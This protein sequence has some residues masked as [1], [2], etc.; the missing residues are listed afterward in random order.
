MAKNDYFY[1]VYKILDY[2]YTQLKNG[3][4]ID[5]EYLSIDSPLFMYINEKYLFYIFDNL[6][7]DGYI[8]GVIV[9]KH[10]HEYGI[11][12]TPNASITPKGIEYLEENN[13][14]N[15]VKNT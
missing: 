6:I 1:L 15:K 11:K 8:R 13:I 12:I 7:K 4:E 10:F 2:M 9:L 5:R 14:F 3:K